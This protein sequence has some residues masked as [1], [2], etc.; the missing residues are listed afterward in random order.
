MLSGT[1]A[2]KKRGKYILGLKDQILQTET[3]VGSN[4]SKKNF[5]WYGHIK[6]W[7]FLSDDPSRIGPADCQ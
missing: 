7:K 4:D 6:L 1:G 3:S 2:K 5:L